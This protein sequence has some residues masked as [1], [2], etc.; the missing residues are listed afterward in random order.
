M[1]HT[2]DLSRTNS[3]VN[4]L[5]SIDEQLASLER[6]SIRHAFKYNLSP[7]RN[8]K[9]CRVRVENLENKNLFSTTE[10]VSVFA[11]SSV[12]V[13]VLRRVSQVLYGLSNA[14]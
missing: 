12:P 6:L 5:P 7:E 13:R 2:R 9:F 11:C 1:L 3:G 14:R 10:R 8:H 4:P